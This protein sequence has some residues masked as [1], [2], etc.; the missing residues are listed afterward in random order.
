MEKEVKKIK[1]SKVA[2]EVLESVLLVVITIIVVYELGINFDGFLN[3]SN[4]MTRQEVIEL[5]EK[6]KEYSNY[7]YSP[8][9]SFSSD[10]TEYFI[11]DNVIKTV[12]NGKTILW[13]NYN[14]DERIS[15]M[16]EHNGK[17]Y[18]GTS[19]MSESDLN[20]YSQAGFDYSLIAD[21]EHFNF[22]FKYLGEKEINGRTYVLVKV[23]NSGESELLST[24]FLIDKEIGLIAERSDYYFLGI[25]LMRMDCDRNLVL[26]GVTD[27]DVEKPDLNEYEILG[28]NKS[29]HKADEENLDADFLFSEEGK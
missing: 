10:K 29:E 11:K 20:E 25:L 17:L 21:N 8:S 22:E 24:K 28:G 19:K 1:K 13:E 27:K 14:T 9:D 4:I 5:L 15:I 6:G 12:Y 26:D 16:G 3:R 18:A 7:Y 2:I 23:W